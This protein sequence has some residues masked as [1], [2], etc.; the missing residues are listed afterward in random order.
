MKK[1][2]VVGINSYPSS[3]LL[4]CINDASDL[5]SILETHGDGSPNFD[6]RL[7]IDVQTRSML[8]K[9]ISELFLGINDTV[10]LYFSGHGFLNELGGYIVTPD[11]ETYDEGISMDEILIMANQSKAK[12]K[13]IILDCCHSGAFG[14]PKIGR[15]ASML[16]DGI[17][18]LTASRDD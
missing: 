10:L 17:T 8:K 12:D 11:H 9:M 13:I 18:I 15:G 3:P 6:I 16:D 1:A 2:L 4:A 14:S 5:A 7:E